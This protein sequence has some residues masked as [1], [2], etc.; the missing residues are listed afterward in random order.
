MQ[1][2]HPPRRSVIINPK[3][4]P[5]IIKSVKANKGE[6]ILYFP[7]LSRQ[8]SDAGSARERTGQKKITN[9]EKEEKI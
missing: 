8:R 9:D 7:K 4:N 2:H 3:E 1:Q 5:I 6:G